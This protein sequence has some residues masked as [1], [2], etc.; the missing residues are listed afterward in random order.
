MNWNRGGNNSGLLLFVAG[1][2]G[3]PTEKRG[4][5]ERR[6][7][8]EQLRL[9]AQTFANAMPRGTHASVRKRLRE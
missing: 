9:G 8:G 5:F 2:S 4:L 1:F 3:E 7:G 6:Q